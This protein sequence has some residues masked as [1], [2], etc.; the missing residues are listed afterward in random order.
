MAHC[1]TQPRDPNTLNADILNRTHNCEHTHTHTL[2]HKLTHTHTHGRCDELS[3]PVR[4]PGAGEADNVKII[5]P[6][7]E[8]WMR[9]GG[10]GG[11]RVGDE[12]EGRRPA[13]RKGGQGKE[14]RGRRQGGG[15]ETNERKP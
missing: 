6:G 13:G 11:N 10:E 15:K 9:E 5:R 7:F 4:L 12:Q 3:V 8:T 14:V 1:D 2:A